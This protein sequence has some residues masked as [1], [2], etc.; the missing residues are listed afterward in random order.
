M[1]CLTILLFRREGEFAKPLVFLSNFA[2]ILAQN[3]YQTY[4]MAAFLKKQQHSLTLDDIVFEHRNKGYGCYYIRF[5]Y[6]R[7]LRFSFILV[8]SSFICATGIIYAWKINPLNHNY[9]K[10]DDRFIRSVNYNSDIIPVTVQMPLEHKNEQVSLNQLSKPV[11]ASGKFNRTNNPAEVPLVQHKLVIPV[12]DTLLKKQIEDLLRK[13]NDNLTKEKQLLTDSLSI[14]LEK[15]P[16]F[17]GGYAAIQ[18]YFYKNQHYPEGAILAGI[19]GSTIVSFIVNE[20]GLVEDARVVS[21]IDPE[22]DL[23]AIRMVNIMPPWKPGIYKGKPVSCMLVLP[24]N[25]TIR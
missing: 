16:Q 20:K 6:Q 12:A 3:L 23:E 14:I 24:V 19:Q 11:Y 21:G 10:Y 4:L 17:P 25:F 18:S 15:V 1:Y 5:T 22:L 7:R 2:I 9:V 13:H 8:L